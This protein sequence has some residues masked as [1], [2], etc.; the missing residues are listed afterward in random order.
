MPNPCL[1]ISAVPSVTSSV[2]ASSI[3]LFHSELKNS[4][5]TATAS[6]CSQ[7]LAT[8]TCSKLPPNPELVS[9]G[10]PIATILSPFSSAKSNVLGW[11][12]P[13]PITSAVFISRSPSSIIQATVANRCLSRLSLMDSMPNLR[14]FLISS[15]CSSR[16]FLLV[17]ASRNSPGKL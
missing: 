12:I 7:D 14:L 6:G 4:S 15:I 10:L 1:I 8:M 13:S 3:L 9:L 16:Y 2:M 17:T 11:K 5:C